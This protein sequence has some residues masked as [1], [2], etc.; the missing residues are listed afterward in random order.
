L[1]ENVA[2][3]RKRG[4]IYKIVYKMLMGGPLI[5]KTLDIEGIVGH[6]IGDIKSFLHKLIDDHSEF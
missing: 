3:E 2:V 5:L 1:S 6:Y 4:G